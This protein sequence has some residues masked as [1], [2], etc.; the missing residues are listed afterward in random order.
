M[1]TLND[2]VEEFKF[3]Y[4]GKEY[5]LPTLDSI[6]AK[7]A[8]EI[9]SKTPEEQTKASTDFIINALE[10]ACGSD[11]LNELTSRQFNELVNAWTQSSTVSLGE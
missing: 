11:I 8:L 7:D 6:S 9:A 3:T 2:A 1:F 10:T 5:A 4:K